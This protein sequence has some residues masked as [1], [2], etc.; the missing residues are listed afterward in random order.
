MEP[1][2]AVVSPVLTFSAYRYFF[3]RDCTAVSHF[4]GG[5]SPSWTQPKPGMEMILYRANASE[6]AAIYASFRQLAQP[7][8]FPSQSAE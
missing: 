8:V 5:P 6:Q 7:P 2:L 1:I 3:K 4:K